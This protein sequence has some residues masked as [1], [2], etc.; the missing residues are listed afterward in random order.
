MHIPSLPTGPILSAAPGLLLLLLAGVGCKSDYDITRDT[1]VE[2]FWQPA[3]E[4][5][6]DILWVVDDSA[7]MYEEQAQLEAHAESF[8]GYLSALPVDFRLAITSTDMEDDDRAGRLLGAVMTP[9]TPALAEVFAEQIFG[10]GEGS[11]DERG[12]EAALLAAE[13]GGINGPDFARREADLE[14]IFFSD[15][16]D[17]STLETGALLDG[18]GADRQ[19]AVV[20]SAVV[21]D[22]PEGCASLEAAADAGLRYIAVQEQSGGIRES[23]CAL[24][25]GAMLER[26]ALQVLGLERTFYLAKVPDPGTMEVWVDGALLPARERHGWM[27]DP[28]LNAVVFDGYAVPRPGAGVVVRYYEWLGPSEAIDDAANTTR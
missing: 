2:S 28:G 16:D 22:P 13:P 3:R 15:E 10:S 23:I 7:S 12:F 4:G 1:Q 25:Y 26:V 17:G 19:G 27:Y 9:E 11:R 5:G 6:V 18:L 24:D 14:V 8:T 20:L 21:G